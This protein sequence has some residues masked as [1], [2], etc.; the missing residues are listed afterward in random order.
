MK[1]C[2]FVRPFID[3]SRFYVFKMTKHVSIYFSR[4]PSLETVEKNKLIG[5]SVI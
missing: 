1:L 5:I 4:E 3:V 2:K